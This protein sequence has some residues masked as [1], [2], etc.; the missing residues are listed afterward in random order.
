MRPAHASPGPLRPLARYLS[1]HAALAVTAS[2]GA[3]VILGL[4]AA[5]AW[6]YDAVAEKDGISGPD[7][8]TLDHVIALRTPLANQLFTVFTHL[9][10]P[11]YMTLIASAVTLLMVWLWRSL[12][13]LILMIIAVAGSLTFTK[14][15]KAIVGRPRPP[16]SDAVPPYE[17]AFS[18]PS[19]HT[20]NST[21]IAG[22]VAYLV[23]SR[24]TSRL[25]IALCVVLA[26][27]WAVAMGFSRIFLGHHWL[28][29]VIFAWFLGLAWLA[30]LITAHRMFLAA[31]KPSPKSATAEPGTSQPRLLKLSRTVSIVGGL[32]WACLAPV[33]L[34]ADSALDE[35]AFT[36]AVAFMW[37]VGVGS[38]LL[39]LL[40]LAQLW[41]LGGD[42]LGRLGEAGVV[43]SALA[44]AAMAL[45]NGI[46]LYAVT[47]RGTESDIGHMI[48]LIAFLILIVASILLGQAFIRR[49]WGAAVRWSG[50]LLLLASP[51][52]IPFLILGAALSP[53]TE[54][55]F[56]SA[57]SVPYALARVLLAVFA[58]QGDMSSRPVITPA[59]DVTGSGP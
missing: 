55:G 52:G 48:F 34:Y 44:L 39:L 50:L 13:P 14:V 29:D 25:G 46:E 54:L 38:L 11:L 49:R 1:T 56:W 8:P 5:S 27:A 36:L 2:V 26:V 40:G 31:S 21:V 3:L 17:H 32:L 51:L 28:T 4:T 37:L 16:L 7:R 6:V 18:F 45:G 41:S 19:G 53:D 30:L 20:L 15:G 9:G 12:T 33:F 10:G 57:L 43:I 42:A 47:V 23:A 59:I 24:L 22:M 35:P 58:P